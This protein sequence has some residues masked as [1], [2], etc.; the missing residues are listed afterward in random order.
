MLELWASE[1]LEVALGMQLRGY[2]SCKFS[3]STMNQCKASSS[4]PGS[5]TVFNCF[6]LIQDVF[7]NRLR[8]TV[9]SVQKNCI[10]IELKCVETDKYREHYVI[11]HENF[12]TCITVSEPIGQANLVTG[13]TNIKDQDLGKLLLGLTL[14]CNYS[15][16]F[17]EHRRSLH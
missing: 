14:M 9:K 13:N 10:L 16:L 4:K 1:P 7:F 12:V 15:H 5:T 6:I 8:T 17:S 2:L 11:L 3:K